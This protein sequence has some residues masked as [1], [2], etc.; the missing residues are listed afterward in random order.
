MRLTALFLMA[1]LIG[2]AENNKIEKTSMSPENPFNVAL[3]EPIDYA[4]VTS[5]HLKAYVS[6]T[7]SNAVKGLDEIKMT[8]ELNFENTFGAYDRISNDNVK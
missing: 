1:L 4:R 2:C 5:T 7:I 6:V 3:N 8:D